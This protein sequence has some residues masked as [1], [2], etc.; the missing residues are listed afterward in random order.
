MEWNKEMTF[1]LIELY[2]EKRI[3]W[4]P[5]HAEYKNR[6]KKHSAWIELSKEMKIQ[7]NEAEKKM[8]ILVG[9]FQREIKKGKYEGD[10]IDASYKSKWIFFKPFLFL[11]DKTH[12]KEKIHNSIEENNSLKKSFKQISIES[13]DSNSNISLL[14]ENDNYS[15]LQMRGQTKSNSSG[16]KKKADTISEESHSVCPNE[17]PNEIRTRDEFD[18]FGEIVAYSLRKL[19]NKTIQSHVKFDVYNILYR[20]EIENQQE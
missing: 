15:N 17:L 14:I 2:R 6:S 9:Q 5:M 4:D 16:I 11:K 13:Q 1:R 20:A 10:G 7:T 8:R 19:K 12:I 3:L 18:V